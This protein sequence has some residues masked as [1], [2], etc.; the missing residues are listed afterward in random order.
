MWWTNLGPRLANDWVQFTHVRGPKE[1][2]G[3]TNMSKVT[4]TLRCVLDQGLRFFLFAFT[5][6]L[7]ALDDFLYVFVMWNDLPN[8]SWSVDNSWAISFK[9]LGFSLWKFSS[10]AGVGPKHAGIIGIIKGKDAIIII[11]DLVPGFCKGLCICLTS[12]IASN[13]TDFYPN[14]NSVALLA[15]R[16]SKHVCTSLQD[17]SCTLQSRNEIC[18]GGPLHPGRSHCRIGSFCT[19]RI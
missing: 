1:S 15:M 11:T 2:S 13:P 14:G 16:K 10:T 12:C 19:K 4:H 8:T 7:W 5:K 17:Q 6:R 18:S 3:A 9:Y